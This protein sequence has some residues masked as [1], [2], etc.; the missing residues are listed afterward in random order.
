MRTI[1]FLAALLAPAITQAQTDINGSRTI[2]GKWD[3][4][5]AVSTKPVKV[6]S[7]VPATCEA[8][9]QLFKTDAPAGQNL[10][11]CTAANTWT[12][13]KGGTNCT[14]YTVSYTQLTAA[15]TAQNLTLLTMPARAKI[16]GLSVKESTSFACSGSCTGISSMT[17][18]M[19]RAG[20]ET[21]YSPAIALMQ[22][23]SDTNAYDDGGQYSATAAAHDV[24]ARFAVTNSTPG[25][26]GNGMA[27]R[28][29]AGSLDIWACTLV[30]P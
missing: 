22:P 23:V 30:L 29:T 28:L 14:K 24:V 16:A 13:M 20:T 15:A 6:G 19:G 2:S 4:S 11:F 18:S 10:Y 3:A 9:E 26:L 21:D 25:N 12:Q 5:G 8:G 7:T 1:V 17:V 27:T